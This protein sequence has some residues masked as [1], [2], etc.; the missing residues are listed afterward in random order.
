M[1]AQNGTRLTPLYSREPPAAVAENPSAP[2]VGAA[3]AGAP[4]TVGLARSLFLLLRMT[5]PTGGVAPVPSRAAA[6]PSRAA[7]V[8][9]RAAAA[10]SKKG[11]NIR[12]EE[13]GRRFRELEDEEEA[14]V[15]APPAAMGGMGAPPAAVEDPANTVGASRDAVRDEVREEDSST[16]AEESSS[17]DEDEDEEDDD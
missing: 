16:E 10:G 15:G 14:C 9:S 13:G 2:S 8:P 7:A 11:K 5:T 3:T 6:V 4:L 12:E 1:D 17:E